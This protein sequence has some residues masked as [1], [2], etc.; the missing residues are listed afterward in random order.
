MYI[1]IIL[2][3]IFLYP[4]SGYCQNFDGYMPTNAFSSTA[5]TP[6]FVSRGNLYKAIVGDSLEL[7]CKVEDL[8]K[9]ENVLLLLFFLFYGIFIFFV[10]FFT[11]F[12]ID[13]YYIHL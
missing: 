2:F 5:A 11:L 7:P 6:K 3:F 9:L 10:Y 8:G 12:Y 4:F 1:R 13:T